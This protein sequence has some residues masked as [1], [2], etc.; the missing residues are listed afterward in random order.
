M[1][2]IHDGAEDRISNMPEDIIHH[3]LSFLD[4]KYAFQFCTLSP[5]WENIWTS[6]RH[7]NFNNDAFSSISKFDKF[8]EEAL[9]HR[10]NQT[11]VC[12]VKLRFTGQRILDAVIDTVD[13]AY[14]HNV[15]QLTIE[16]GNVYE[17]PQCL[18]SSPTLKH[19]SLSSSTDT[20]SRVINSAWNM[21][22]LETLY[23][24]GIRFGDTGDT[25][26]NLFHECVKLTSLTLEKCSMYDLEIFY[27]CAPNLL[28]LTITRTSIF[29]EVFHVFAP[30]LETLTADGYSSSYKFLKLSTEEGF[31]SLE[32][33][34]LSLSSNIQKRE[35]HVPSLLDLFK[36]VSNAKSL[37]LD[38][39]ITEVQIYVMVIAHRS[40]ITTL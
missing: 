21:P 19:L 38:V 3:I 33:V 7:L 15:K 29:P 18:F 9:S 12:A 35:K 17:L 24:R 31:S 22:A 2:S 37:I 32:K 34:N 39:N 28:N 23:L 4:T 36:K 11:E 8:M 30:Q 16:C 14:L 25:S 1:G 5:K 13:Y 10:N 6:M 27:I 40:C 26:F 20:K